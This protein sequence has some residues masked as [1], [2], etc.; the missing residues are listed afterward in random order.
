M[1]K[2]NRFLAGL[3]LSGAAL[4]SA[5]GAAP[6]HA[7]DTEAMALDQVADIGQPGGLIGTVAFTGTGLLTG[8]EPKMPDPHA[9]VDEAKKQKAEEDAKQAAGK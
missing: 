6:A 9:I 1:I 3:A 7:A 5:L 4:A 8:V 2:P